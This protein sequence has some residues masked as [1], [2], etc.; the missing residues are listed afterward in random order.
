[1]QVQGTASSPPSTASEVYPA[2]QS[3][4]DAC[5]VACSRRRR[6]AG[7]GGAVVSE[8]DL[9]GVERLQPFDGPIV[10]GLIGSA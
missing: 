5:V 8:G 7:P 9:N 2:G 3:N 1:L 10:G 6:S 4:A